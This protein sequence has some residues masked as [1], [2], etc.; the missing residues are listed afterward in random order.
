MSEPAREDA[1]REAV[2]E[3]VRELIPDVLRAIP[4]PVQNGHSQSG[5]SPNDHFPA[6]LEPVPLVPAPPVAA[7]LRPSTWTGPAVPGEIVGGAAGPGETSAVDAP[8][9]RPAQAF[10]AG[11]TIETIRIESD[12]D[13]QVFVR[14]LLTRLESPRDRLAIKAGRLR[15]RLQR[16][17]A[18]AG[19]SKPGTAPVVRVSRGAVSERAVR[20]AHAAGARLLLDR[21]AVLTPLA[22]D[23][24]RALGVQIEREAQC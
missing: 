24:A 18:A 1:I 20:D 5:H 21:R 23:T 6:S 22:R 4:A 14:S 10:S 12:E 11:A 19:E 16:S 9:A 3:A 17:A 13:L 2:R 15:F 8:A 7:V